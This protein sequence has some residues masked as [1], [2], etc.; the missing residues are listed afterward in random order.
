[1]PEAIPADVP[2]AALVF[3]VVA[4]V[5]VAGTL[6]VVL[7]G[8]LQWARPSPHRVGVRWGAETIEVVEWRRGKGRVLAGGE[9]WSA[10][11]PDDLAPG[12]RVSVARTE[13]LTLQVRRR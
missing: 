4:S 10:C 11:G 3:V 6:A 12:D 2:I 1:M 7:I 5:A 8:V 13:G 9:L